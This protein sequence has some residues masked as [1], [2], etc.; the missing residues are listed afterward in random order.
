MRRPAG[1]T[2]YRV[3]TCVGAGNVQS[4]LCAVRRSCQT[5]LRQKPRVEPELG[6]LGVVRQ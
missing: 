2:R 3:S 4:V 6:V 1:S 5:P